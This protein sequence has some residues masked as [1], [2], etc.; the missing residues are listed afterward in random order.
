M[1]V[2]FRVGGEVVELGIETAEVVAKVGVDVEGHGGGGVHEVVIGA[3]VA[4]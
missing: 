3:V 1:I 2:I 4:W